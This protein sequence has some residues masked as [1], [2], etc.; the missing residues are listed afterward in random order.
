MKKLLLLALLICGI[1]QA[2]AAE[3]TDSN[4]I[5]WTFTVSGTNAT[6]IKPS[7]RSTISSAVTI[8]SEVNGYTV[9]SIGDDAFRGCSGLT[10]V[11]IQ[12]GIT[13][14]GDCSF[15]DCTK[16]ERI[17]IPSTVSTVEYG[18][19]AGCTKLNH[20]EC[21]AATPPNAIF[22]TDV[23]DEPI[24]ST[25][26]TAELLV[27]PASVTAYRNAEVWSMFQNIESIPFWRGYWTD[28][29]GVTWG[30]YTRDVYNNKS[31]IFSCS[32]A[33]GEIVI[34][35]KLYEG[36]FSV[37]ISG[38]GGDGFD[39][40]N[41]ENMEWNNCSGVTS[42]VVPEG[43]GVIGSSF[44]HRRMTE[45]GE[46]IDG[47]PNLKRLTLPSTFHFDE[48][49]Y[50]WTIFSVPELQEIIISPNHPHYSSGTNNDAI[51]FIKDNG[52]ISLEI[53]F[54]NTVIQ[55]GTCSLD[56]DAFSGCTGLTSIVIPASV[57][58]IGDCVFEGCSSLSKIY[59]KS[60]TP[61]D[62]PQEAPFSASTYTSA[63]LYVPTGCKAAYRSAETWSK[64]THVLEF[65]PDAIWTFTVSGTNATITGCTEPTGTLTIPSQVV[66]NGTVYNV[67][68]IGS[69]AFQDCTGIES[70]VMSDGLK[71]IGTLAFSNCS[72]LTDIVI[73][74]S[75]TTIG[76][77][78]FLGCSSLKSVT[79]PESLNTIGGHAFRD[80]SSLTSLT[81]PESLT[82]IGERGFYGCSKL[83]SLTIGQNVTS[84]GE[85]AFW[86]C[87]KLNS[88]Q[89]VI[90]DA[91]AFCSNQVMGLINTRSS[92]PVKL[93]NTEGQAITSFTVP[94]AV[95]A[96]GENAFI[97]ATGLTSV[98]IPSG[99][100]AIGDNAFSG[101]SSLT[102]VNCD[103]TTPLVITENTFT[104]RSNAVLY[105]PAGCRAAYLN[106]DYWSDFKNILVV[107]AEALV[108]EIIL[109]NNS[110]SLLLGEEA[111]LSA[112]VLPDDALNPEV[113]WSTSDPA[114]ATVENGEV[115][116][117]GIGMATIT[118][119]AVDGSGVS[120]SCEV[121]VTAPSE[122]DTDYSTIDNT[123]Y[124]ERTEGKTGGQVTLSVKMKNTV[125]VQGFQ[126]DLYL[127]EGVTVATD[128]EGFPM[129]QLS[130]ERTTKQKTDY[131][132][133]SF[134]PDGSLRVLCGST[135][136]YV[137]DG[138]D[139][140][141]ALITLNISSDMEEGD[142]PLILKE[143][144]V[145]DLNSVSYNTDYLK[146]TLNLS[147]YTLG[148]VN[149]DGKINVSDF[150]AVANHILGRTTTTTFIV[151]AADVNFDNNI[152][153]S[154]F[155]GIA[156]MIL[157][158]TTTSGAN[159]AVMSAPRRADGVS[160]TNID[161][162][163]N[164]LYIAPVTVAPGKQAVLS[165]RMKNKVPVAGFEFNLRLPEGV[166]VAVDGD[167]K[168]MAE[169]SSERT[170]ERNTN[171]FGSALQADGTLKVLCGTSAGDQSGLCSFNGNEGEVA[172][173][174]V[175]IP[176]DYA[177]GDYAVTVANGVLS[178]VNAATIFL[179]PELAISNAYLSVH[180]SAS[181]IDNAPIT[182]D[183][184]PSGVY[185]TLDGMK[186][187]GKPS[188]RGVYVVNGK[189]VVVK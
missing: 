37:E 113:E 132:D 15:K 45:D 9:T 181:A 98:T 47:L 163:D 158:G 154:D 67:T 93:V 140:E 124:L 84:I 150:I 143:V 19:F 42:I 54:N 118:V 135:K 57:T 167:G 59:C 80:C 16:L 183:N 52:S 104:N 100:T 51:Y 111:T 4:G 32:N 70:V 60:P 123:I 30:Y 147:S 24:F 31:S 71:T 127:P 173:I 188:K 134:R 22:Y 72:G 41:P 121:T 162:L 14:I 29:N 130:T 166:T 174:T 109:D 69:K 50:P 33:T 1:S 180:N 49:T 92:R 91:A 128:E 103:I 10:S 36:D 160:P 13:V 79:L 101:C 114:V 142:Y 7:D 170:T 44:Y 64:F 117:V 159:S 119:T 81:L 136:G 68:A 99:V 18:A 184:A 96:I 120:A 5:N 3:W 186:L 107:G 43:I 17:T 74:S 38:I 153:V 148:D 94:D 89:V 138:E 172:R 187:N 26:N 39:E 151:K 23:D 11:Y 25:Y 46:Y 115:T 171:F 106:A 178:D 21:R 133:S 65:D 110:L 97:N 6:D 66:K 75:V 156:N 168:P 164:A 35:T 63:T 90:S 82:S 55:E 34:P 53:G 149:G 2:W 155:I 161:A 40:C 122:A 112:S 176:A 86:G 62:A 102:T 105:V 78:A 169:L 165:L 95:D 108:E 129:A 141:V 125:E 179:K 76:K 8:P 73:P 77:Q 88:V 182:L 152:N 145:S 61:P 58:Y 177:E 28:E 83:S 157:R 20:I 139:G 146:S 126:F 48:A 116:A 144:S 12:E 175:N 131:F 85:G 87:S 56:D 137:F 185:F 27:P 189:K